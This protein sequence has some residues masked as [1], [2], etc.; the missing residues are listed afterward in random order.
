MRITLLRN[1]TWRQARVIA[2]LPGTVTVLVPTAILLAGGS[3]IG[4]GLGGALVA[5]PVLL[6]LA[7]IAA[8]F[9]LW[10]WTVRLFARVGEGTLA[11]WD[12]TRH[13][14]V[15]GPYRHVRNP[16][17]TAVLA[18]LAG[19]AVLFGSAP[20]LIWLAAFLAINWTFFWLF[21]EPALERRFGDDYRSYKRN[22]P[23]W[24]PRRTPWIP[25]Q[26]R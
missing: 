23:R 11:P 6:G 2:L 14:A 25:P 5:L 24:L 17:I 20:L 8:G 4:W 13:L 26:S 15:E 12:P 16:M 7:L 21:E 18:V 10:L 19:E 3:D 22:V 1:A 9:A